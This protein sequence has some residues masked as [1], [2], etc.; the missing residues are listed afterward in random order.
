[1]IYSSNNFS[2]PP[3]PTQF[4][5]I[6]LLFNITNSLILLLSITIFSCSIAPNLSVSQLLL[7]YIPPNTLNIPTSS[8]SILKSFTQYPHFPALILHPSKYSNFC[9][10]IP[11]T[12]FIPSHPLNIQ[13]SLVL[14][15]QNLFHPPP[16]IQ[17]SC[18]I[19]PLLSI[20]HNFSWFISLDFSI[21][22][23]LLFY[24]SIPGTYS[25]FQLL[26]SSNLLGIP[27]SPVLFL[28][29]SQY[30][31]FSCFI[32]P[33]PLNIPSSPVLFL[34]TLL[35]SQ[36]LLFY[37]SQLYQYPNFYFSCLLSPTF[38]IFK[39][40]PAYVLTNPPSVISTFFSNPHYLRI[41]KEVK[42]V[43]G[44]NVDRRHLFLSTS[45]PLNVFWL[46]V[47]KHFIFLVFHFH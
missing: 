17:F 44:P 38:I 12:L 13:T 10:F 5:I 31:N 20:H 28:Q 46:S 33:N 15:L 9:Y 43:R 30:P 35:I 11:P 14:F 3:S 29:R 19:I 32:P 25:V 16:P 26:Y 37:S 4:F 18:S 6:L 1:M 21:P 42:S 36:L 8:F 45:N 7:F 27:T 39:L 47:E 24:S 34:Q 40:P 41:H 23:I 2:P 22:P